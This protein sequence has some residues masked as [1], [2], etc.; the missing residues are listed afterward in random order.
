VGSKDSFTLSNGD[1]IYYGRGDAGEYV[2]MLGGFEGC[3]EF[4]FDL[5]LFW[6]RY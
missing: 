1:F 6:K 4:E 3:I 2:G 5:N